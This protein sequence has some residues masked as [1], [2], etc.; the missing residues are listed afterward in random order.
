MRHDDFSKY[1]L[2]DLKKLMDEH[3]EEVLKAQTKYNRAKTAKTVFDIM[4]YGGW[5]FTILN[6][7]PILKFIGLGINLVGFIGSITLISHKYKLKT[8]MEQAEEYQK[9]IHNEVEHRYIDVADSE[10]FPDIFA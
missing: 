9:E 3:Q 7:N 4:T 5:A 1:D 10:I 8:K 6:S 2:E